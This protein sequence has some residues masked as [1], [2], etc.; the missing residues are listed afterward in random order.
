MING[1]KLDF[2][3]IFCKP[4]LK[5]WLRQNSVNIY[6]GLW[7]RQKERERIRM[8][9]LIID[10][11][12]HDRVVNSEWATISCEDNWE[13]LSNHGIQKGNF[14]WFI[15]YWGWK[16]Y[17]FP[18]VLLFMSKKV[19]TSIL[20]EGEKCIFFSVVRFQFQIMKSPSR[21]SWSDHFLSWKLNSFLLKCWSKTA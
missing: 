2:Y 7:W 12:G 6:P 20:Q 18:F 21:V 19:L 15:T 16:V 14:S 11:W 5:L 17:T 10:F 9:I 8:A 3:F 1:C 13:K 4:Y